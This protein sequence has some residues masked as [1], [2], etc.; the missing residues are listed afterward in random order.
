MLVN[1]PGNRHPRGHGRAGLRR[2]RRRR[3]DRADAG[4]RARPRCCGAS[5][6]ARRRRSRPPR[7]RPL[8]HAAFRSRP[9]RRRR[10][11]AGRALR[12]SDGAHRGRRRAQGRP[13]P[14]SRCPALEASPAASAAPS[15]ASSRVT[16]QRKRGTRWVTAAPRQGL[17]VQA[18]D[19][20]GRDQAASRAAPT[21]S[22]ATFEGTG[23][24]APLALRAARQSLALDSAAR[25]A[26]IALVCEPPDGGVAEHVGPAG[27]RVSP[28]TGTSRSVAPDSRPAG[29]RSGATTRTRTATRRRSRALDARAAAASISSTPTRPRRA[30]S[31]RLAARLRAP[32]RRLHAARLPVRGR[33][34]RGAAGASRSRSS[35]ARAADRRADLRL[36]VRARAR[37]RATSCS[38]A[39][40]RRAQRLPAVRC[41]GRASAVC[42]VGA[43]SALR[44]QKR[45]DVLLD[46]APRILDAVPGATV[47]IAGDG[48]AGGRAA[49]PPADP[50]VR[51]RAVP[52]AGRRPPARARR[53]R[54]RLELGGVPDRRAGGAGVRRAAGR[55]RRR[56]HARGGHA[57]DRP[58]DPAA[59]SG[60]AG[61][62][63]DRA[64]AATPQRRARMAR[65]LTRAC[66]PSASPSSGWSPATAAV[67][68][69]V[70]RQ[71]APRP[72]MTAG[73]VARRISMSR[74][75]DQPAT[76]W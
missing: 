63:R 12:R 74:A 72:E 43:V 68:D 26:R 17:G 10:R 31:A 76:Y 3:P 73:S 46:A 51:L 47:V 11:G 45:V 8:S 50:R 4:R 44:R 65:R 64:A 71:Y 24:A 33:D 18:R 40:R 28:P 49:A 42:V 1:P 7:P 59:R 54:A 57:R 9:R 53:L 75:S 19:A 13:R 62:R 69:D 48:P 38:R 55:H 20:S 34:A 21:A 56:R 14:P 5:P 27:A 66:T 2:P 60:R 41:A 70:L 67:Y 58:A 37:A 32:A 25:M 29:C 52:P 16:V 39:A 6:I 35:G 30:W 15:A 22:I 23:T 36:R 61:R